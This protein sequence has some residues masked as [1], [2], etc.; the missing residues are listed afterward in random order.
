MNL[1]VKWKQGKKN[2][3]NEMCERKRGSGGG[4][5]THKWGRFQDVNKAKRF[6][7]SGTLRL[8]PTPGSFY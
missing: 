4:R 6:R 5:G 7:A 3:R 1:D 2:K 8:Q